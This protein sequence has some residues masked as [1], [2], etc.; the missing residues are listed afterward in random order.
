TYENGIL[1]RGVT[2]GDGV[3]GDDVTANVRTIR[4]IPLKI[5]NGTV[6]PSFEVRGEIFM[7]KEVFL[8]LNREREDIG[9]ERY[10]NARN[11]TSGTMKMQDSTIVA[12]RKLD[13]FAYYLLGDESGIET[14]EEAIKKLEEWGFHVS[15]TY[16]KCNT[17]EEVLAYIEQWETKR[18]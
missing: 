2:R 11:T 7:T 8:Q 3:R 6:P 16:Q 18:I 13:C 5:R 1:V 12:Q 9:E 10:A 4:S 14:H 15:P 17:M